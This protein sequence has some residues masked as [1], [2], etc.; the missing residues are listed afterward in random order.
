MTFWTKIPTLNSA[1]TSFLTVITTSI[2]KMIVMGSISRMSISKSKEI[3]PNL[4]MTSFLWTKI[5][6]KSTS[7]SK[8]TSSK[9]KKGLIVLRSLL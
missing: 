2:I 1:R 3:L 8:M 6:R 7:C 5:F 9:T 4:F